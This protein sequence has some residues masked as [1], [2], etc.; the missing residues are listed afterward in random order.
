MTFHGMLLFAHAYGMGV[1]WYGVVWRS[2]AAE[3]YIVWQQ[4]CMTL[5][6]R[7]EDAT[8]RLLVLPTLRRQLMPGFFITTRYASSMV[9]HV[10]CYD[11]IYSG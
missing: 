4:Q 8:F 10:A 5:F 9:W 11:M 7:R 3:Y 1:A 6:S 2:M